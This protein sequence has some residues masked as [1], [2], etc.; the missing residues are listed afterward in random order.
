MNIEAELKALDAAQTA[1]AAVLILLIKQLAASGV[2]DPR[3][4]A[5]TLTKQAEQT[6]RDIRKHPQPDDS[7]QIVTTQYIQAMAR[8]ILNQPEPP[9]FRPTVVA[10]KD[11]AP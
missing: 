6:L 1:D 5:D 11:D 7:V 2:L 4:L 10:S 9:E 8:K 3:A